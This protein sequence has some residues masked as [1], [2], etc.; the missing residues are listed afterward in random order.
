MR[1]LAYLVHYAVAL[2]L[3]AQSIQSF[4][5]Y[6]CFSAAICDLIF[7]ISSPNEGNIIERLM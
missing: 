4:I 5:L 1:E 7:F 3:M 2:V 6:E